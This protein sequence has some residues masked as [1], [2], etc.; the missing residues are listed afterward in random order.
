MNLLGVSISI[1][2]ETYT[3]D[4]NFIGKFI[5]I[6]CG[7]VGVGFGI[8]LFSL[9]LKV[10]T[11]PF[12]VMQRI[13]MRKQNI[14]MK[15]QKERMEKLQKQMLKPQVWQE[16]QQK[17]LLLDQLHLLVLTILKSSLIA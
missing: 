2:T 6:L 15:E 16:S 17:P 9:V 13:S 14:K 10:I 11:L 5:G 3:V 4:I 8:V 12:D 7:A 1:F